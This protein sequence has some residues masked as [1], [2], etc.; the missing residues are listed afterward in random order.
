[1]QTRLR[2]AWWCCCLVAAW[3]TL[4]QGAGRADEKFFR[5][6]IEPI[7]VRRCLECHA[8]EPRGGLD[9]RTGPTAMRGGDS[10]EAIVSGK[11][12]ESLLYEYVLTKKMPPK[13]PLPAEEV[14]LLKE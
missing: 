5:T 7:L 2:H 8:S 11:P 13:H 1:M 4:A 14:A 10:G 6:R 12:E 9:L 3:G